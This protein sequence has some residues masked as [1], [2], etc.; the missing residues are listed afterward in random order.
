MNKSTGIKGKLVLQENLDWDSI[1]V[2]MDPEVEIFP[3]GARGRIQRQLWSLFE[4]PNSSIG[5]R[6]IGNV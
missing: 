3:E 4:H 5:A 6:V 1:D 2:H